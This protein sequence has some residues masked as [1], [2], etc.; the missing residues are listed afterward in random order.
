VYFTEGVEYNSPAMGLLW[1]VVGI[2]VSVFVSGGV[3]VLGYNPPEFKL[4][5]ACF[6]ASA[7]LLGVT[8]AAWH[9]QTDWSLT[10]RL[11]VAVP[12]WAGVLI[13]LPT[14]LRWIERR[15]AVYVSSFPKPVTIGF[16]LFDES[17]KEVRNELVAQ[18]TRKGKVGF[19]VIVILTV[20][21]SAVITFRFLE[22]HLTTTPLP[23]HTWPTALPPS[24][25]YNHTPP[26]SPPRQ[27]SEDLQNPID[28]I[29]FDSVWGL[30]VKNR[31]GYS[32]FVIDMQITQDLETKYLALSFD[33][34]SQGTKN[35]PIK[36][37]I[38]WH[39][40]PTLADTWKD[41]V[42]SAIKL[43]GSGC[44]MFV[45]F[46]VNDS[47]LSTMKEYYQHRG[48]SLGTGDATGIIHYRL[49]NSSANAGQTV[50]LVA[51]AV[52]IPSCSPK[53]PS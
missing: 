26:P 3:S 31:S 10:G 15:E 40:L 48:A 20:I 53:P 38:D 32:M 4:A 13:G 7:L 50:P 6:W 44:L 29:D 35:F 30:T 45:Y 37:T 39:S 28:V 11:C 5:R 1:T 25:A 47:G 34:A 49:S 42:Q 19:V 41:H 43:Y 22:S 17:G 12:L 51:T 36:S 16:K 24:F 18:P 21:F 14:G 46:S 52:Y 27:S 33:V 23:H 2:L 9:L 8:D